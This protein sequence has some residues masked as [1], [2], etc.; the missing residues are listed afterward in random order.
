M[1]PDRVP[2]VGVDFTLIIFYPFPRVFFLE[3]VRV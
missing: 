3:A 1:P 2:Y